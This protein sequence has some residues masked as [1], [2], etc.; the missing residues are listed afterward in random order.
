MTA[1]AVVTNT[2]R[3][4]YQEA[5]SSLQNAIALYETIVTF[6]LLRLINTLSYLLTYEDSK[7][8]ILCRSLLVRSLVSA[9]SP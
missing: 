4:R 6:W 2:T 1:N 9:R 3:Q 5:T 7:N 8:N